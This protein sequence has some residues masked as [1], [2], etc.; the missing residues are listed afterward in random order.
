M[1]FPPSQSLEG[2][3]RQRDLNAKALLDTALTV[4]D[5]QTAIR[6]AVEAIDQKL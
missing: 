5:L 3:I 2:I 4:R 1:S 6:Q